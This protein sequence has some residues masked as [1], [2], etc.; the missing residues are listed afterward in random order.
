MD[1]KQFITRLSKK[2]SIDYKETAS[3]IASIS[4]AIA[5]ILGNGDSIAIPGFGTFSPVKHDE[6]I[7]VDLSTGK[8][9]LFPPCLTV[10]YTQSS[11]LNKHLSQSN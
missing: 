3:L 4:T 1:N 5:D 11:I 9:I 7:R 2:S 8:R 6:E 10:A